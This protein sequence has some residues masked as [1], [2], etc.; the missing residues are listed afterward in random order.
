MDRQEKQMLADIAAG[1]YTMMT[2]KEIRELFSPDRK[3]KA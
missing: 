1:H 2:R 3:Q